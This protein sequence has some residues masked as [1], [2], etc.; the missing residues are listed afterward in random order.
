M[1]D[2]SLITTIALGL[3]AA[4]LFG[5]LAKRF[6]LSPIVGYL[7]GG[8]AIGPYTPGFV[9]DPKIAAL[10]PAMG[11]ILLMFCVGLHFSLR[12]LLPSA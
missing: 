12:D 11:V 2:I 5:M 8:V 1:H 9:G 4:L 6:G 10:L 7:L 3:T